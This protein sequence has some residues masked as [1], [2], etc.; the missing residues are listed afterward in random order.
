MP[1]P[2]VLLPAQQVV[3]SIEDNA[4]GQFKPSVLRNSFPQNWQTTI[5]AKSAERTAALSVP[6][7]DSVYAGAP[8]LRQLHNGNT[9]LSYQSTNNRSSHWEQSCMQVA[10][11]DKEAKNF[12]PLAAPFEIP[13]DKHGLWNSLCILHDDTIIAITSTNAFTPNTTIWMIKGRL[14]AR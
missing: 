3:F 2:I 12:V 8:F 13:R 1:V 5:D 9:V 6:L 11:G 7:P 14:A 10:M 4:R